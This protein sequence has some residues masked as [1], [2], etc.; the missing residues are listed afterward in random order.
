[1]FREFY[2]KIILSTFFNSSIGMNAFGTESN[3]TKL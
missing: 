1:M 3:T 2:I